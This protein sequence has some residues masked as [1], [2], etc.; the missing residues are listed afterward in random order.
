M[1]P[2]E[3]RIH[4]KS[5]VCHARGVISRGCCFARCRA[6]GP[7]SRR[8]TAWRGG[9]SRCLF[10]GKNDIHNHKNDNDIDDDNDNIKQIVILRPFSCSDSRVAPSAPPPRRRAAHHS[11]RRECA[12]TPPAPALARC[13]VVGGGLRAASEP[14]LAVY[15][16]SYF[17]PPRSL[18]L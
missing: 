16:R 13:G 14:I 5:L 1:A 6:R 2:M 4:V 17:S 8:S 11:G 3:R 10:Y 15:C 12:A 18:R 9:S 7:S